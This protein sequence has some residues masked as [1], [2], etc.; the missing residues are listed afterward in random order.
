MDWWSLLDRFL[1]IFYRA[2]GN[3]VVDYFLG[4]LA[5]SLLAVIV[6]EFTISLVFRINKNHLDRLNSRLVD[7]HNL[8]LTALKL[9]D[10]EN[11]RACNK[12]ANDA[13]GQV[14]F[15]MFGLSAASLWPVF[16]V[17]A[18]M[19][20]RFAGITFPLPFTGL[21]ANY[22]FTF[23]VCYILARI[24]F[25]KIKHRLPYFKGV[26]KMLLDYGENSKRMISVADLTD[27]KGSAG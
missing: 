7:V 17:L 23:L 22:V 20:E 16:F 25:G 11:Y 26:H 5:V 1:I 13:F 12:E 8:S 27:E 10:K 14:F 21:M 18:W 19:Q 3:P 4:T 6:G 15:N 24:F 2:T 9:G